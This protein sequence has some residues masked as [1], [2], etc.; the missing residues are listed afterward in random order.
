MVRAEAASTLGR[1]AIASGGRS[2]EAAVEALA[3]LAEQ[4]RPLEPERSLELRSE[5]LLVMTAVPR[6]R[7]ELAEQ[8]PRFRDQAAGRP[9]FE[10]VARIHTALEQILQGGSA[11]AA[12]EDVEAALAA[13]LPAA[14]ATTAAFLALRTLQLGERYDLALR[15]LDVALERA[16]REGH[17]TR[18]GSSTAGAPRSRSRRVRFRT[19]RS[20]PRPDCCSWRSR[21]SSCSSSS[22]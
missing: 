14:A 19:H 1:C 17:A 2:A 20:R 8:L 3:S 6:V 12:V 16:R 15:L 11:A 21:I 7:A 9:C 4:V 10:A 5:L 22:R 13:G 18:Q